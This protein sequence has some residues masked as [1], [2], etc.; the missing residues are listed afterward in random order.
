MADDPVRRCVVCRTA[1]EGERFSRTS[2]CS[3]RCR[4]I[5]LGR[6]LNE[7]YRIREEGDAWAE[8]EEE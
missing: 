6:W 8:Q 2:F 7:E 5:D 1:L 3:E 4:K